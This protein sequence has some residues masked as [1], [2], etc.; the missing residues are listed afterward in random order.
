MGGGTRGEGGGGGGGGELGGRSWGGGGR[1]GEGYYSHES[2]SAIPW[3]GLHL[4]TAQCGLYTVK[5]RAS[6]NEVTKLRAQLKRVETRRRKLE[7]DLRH[8]H[9]VMVK[10]VELMN[11]EHA[12]VYDSLKAII[13][14]GWDSVGCKTLNPI[15]EH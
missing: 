8:S 15:K 14:F 9:L 4:V 11:L 3:G 7:N 1:G 10:M 12:H 6:Q 13:R 5:C 2:W